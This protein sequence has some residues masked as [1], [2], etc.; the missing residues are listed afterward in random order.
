MDISQMCHFYQ[1]GISKKCCS[2]CNRS[3]SLRETAPRHAGPS[4]DTSKT[5]ES[6]I[7]TAVL[8]PPRWP[9]P[10]GSSP[11]RAGY[12]MDILHEN[13]YCDLIKFCCVLFLACTF[14]LD[15][16]KKTYYYYPFHDVIV[17]VGV[18]V[19][20]G[21]GGCILV[22]PCPSVLPAVCPFVCL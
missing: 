13:R 11:H 10:V 17:V 20:V 9:S 21:K 8:D 14:L 6:F 12:I 16:E 3:H 18:L 5:I 1:A 4:N 7:L 2:L 19:V 15:L 22:S